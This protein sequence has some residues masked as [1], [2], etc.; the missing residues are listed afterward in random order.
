MTPTTVNEQIAHRI[1]RQGVLMQ[2][3]ANQEVY[4]IIGFLNRDVEPDLVKQLQKH[5]G[6]TLTVKR[7]EAM[8]AA[9]K[10]II[11]DG[12]KQVQANLLADMVAQGKL[13]AAATVR[14][15][16]DALPFE[17]SMVTPSVASIREMV[18]NKPINGEFVPDWFKALSLQTQQKVARQIMVGVTEGEGIDKIVRRIV[19]T[20]ANQYRDGVL[21]RTRH[22]V[23][24]VVRTAVAG[25][26]D[27]VRD[28]TFKANA[29][30]IKAVQW[31]A[32]LDTRTCAVC[33]AL[34]GQAFEIDKGPHAPRH[35]QCRCSRVP[36]LKSW[37]ELGLPLQEA[38]P[39]TRASN[40][41][42]RAEAKRLAKLPPDER[43]KIKAQLQGQV[44]DSLP[45]PEWLRR[46]TTDVQNEALGKA[47]AEL[48]RSGKLK[49]EE[50]VGDN[51]RIL[52]L[53]EIERRLQK[54]N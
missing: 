15:I 40:A 9:V 24:S 12:Y 7:V 37:K 47:R 8:Q 39:S 38:G 18:R 11:A 1:I 42:T 45:Y 23:E 32:T 26:S 13:E 43:R 28:G 30:I 4:Q 6:R 52:T 17:I 51:R 19:G 54:N 21:E 35:W 10:T 22:D 29:D 34:D 46:Q 49:I 2:G 36:V 20:R 31:T 3:Y 44:P 27:N 48:F 25:V 5:A 50:F 16:E 53:A 41:I 14:I 33:M